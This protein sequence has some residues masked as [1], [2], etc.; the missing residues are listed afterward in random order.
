MHLPGRRYQR[1]ALAWLCWREEELQQQEQQ[2]AAPSTSKAAAT[3]SNGAAGATAQANG[4]SSRAV[5]NFPYPVVPPQ[6][7]L[8]WEERLL[9]GG[10]RVWVSDFE[11]QVIRT[12]PAP[13]Q[14][15]P[16]GILA[17]EMG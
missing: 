15:P 2:A 8:L 4:D 12:P 3:A 14:R 11:D 1:R 13:W 7:N 10:A 16:G 5:L 9:P 6:A 17:D